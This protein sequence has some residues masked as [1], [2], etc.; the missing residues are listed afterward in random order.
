MEIPTIEFIKDKY[1]FNLLSEECLSI[2]SRAREKSTKMNDLVVRHGRAGFF[3]KSLAIIGELISEGAAYGST[4]CIFAYKTHGFLVY[5]AWNVSIESVLSEQELNRFQFLV[6][7][8]LKILAGIFNR[9][10][11]Q[12]EV[13][14]VKLELKV[15]GWA[16]E[17]MSLH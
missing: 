12:T 9:F 14:P 17:K 4:H 7:Q 8:Q 16:P 13:C 10:G 6:V 11:Y 1:Q 2:Y 5:H 3:D 15:Y